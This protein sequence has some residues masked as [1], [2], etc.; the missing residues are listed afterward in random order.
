VASRGYG[1]D[2]VGRSEASSAPVGAIGTRAVLLLVLSAA[3][4]VLWISLALAKCPSR[5]REFFWASRGFY[6]PFRGT[7][8]H[9]GQRLTR[10]GPEQGK[11]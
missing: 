10:G 1:A 2:A 7:C 4:F 5:G 8:V 11:R 9:C 3:F 6:D